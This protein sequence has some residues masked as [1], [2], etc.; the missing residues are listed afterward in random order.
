MVAVPYVGDVALFVV[1]PLF[2]VPV[3]FMLPVLFTVPV[4]VVELSPVD[5]V[6]GDMLFILVVVGV[7][8]EVELVIVVD[9]ELVLV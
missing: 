5:M 2:T 1:L 8:P 7:V 4:P 9:D 6:G 3:L